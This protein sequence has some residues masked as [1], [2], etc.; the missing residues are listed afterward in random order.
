MIAQELA[1]NFPEKVEK[2]ILC[3]TSCGDR[4]SVLPSQDVLGTLMAGGRVLSPE[5]IARMT[6]PLVFTEDF[7][8]KN[9]DL[10]EFSIQQ[11]LKAPISKEVL[12]NQLN[13]IAQSTPVICCLRSGRLLLF[14]MANGISWYRLRTLPSWLKPYQTPLSST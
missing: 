12:M 5:E 11:I 7:V 14:C 8:K 13:A 4:R 10:L 6:I 1:L 3:S 2:L 9:P